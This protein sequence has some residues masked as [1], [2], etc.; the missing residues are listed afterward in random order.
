MKRKNFFI[1]AGA[2]LLFLTLVSC[3]SGIAVEVTEMPTP[4]EIIATRTPIAES[5]STPQLQPSPTIQLTRWE[6]LLPDDINICKGINRFSSFNPEEPN[7]LKEELLTLLEKEKNIS[8]TEYVDGLL[9]INLNEI[10]FDFGD[11][12]SQSHRPYLIVI[13]EW[14]PIFTS[15]SYLPFGDDDGL[16]VLGMR[17][18]RTEDKQEA[19]IHLAMDDLGFKTLITEGGLDSSQYE[20]EK[21]YKNLSDKR[22]LGSLI[23]IINSQGKST[24][25]GPWKKSLELLN[26][27]PVETKQKLSI[28]LTRYFNSERKLTVDEIHETQSSLEKVLIPCFGL[29]L[30]F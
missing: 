29:S 1:T 26:Y 9:T 11:N 8:E 3:N 13:N 2:A 14:N 17:I 7:L 6:I 21:Y 24:K 10:E 12:P 27:Q 25:E 28:L 18:R 22:I 30:H 16:F 19:I 20:I 23:A 4:T 15:C 5:T